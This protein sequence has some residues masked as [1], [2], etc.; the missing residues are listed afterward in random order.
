METKQF[1]K[2][3]ER[4]LKAIDH[5][6]PEAVNLLLGTAA[7]ESRFGYY[8]RQIK[9]PALGFFQ[10]EPITHDCHVKEY[11]S[12]HPRLRELIKEVSGVSCFNKK[13]LEYNIVYSICMARVHYLRRPGR[14]P[15]DKEGLAK[16]WK[17]HYNTY[18]GRGR[19]SEFL[20]NFDKYVWDF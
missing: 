1:R 19:E 15:S 2:L 12:H 9:G 11:L 13:H 18:L 16:Y 17:D 6:S 4:T 14:I 10:M 7:Q 5:Y 20:I 3:I 8:L